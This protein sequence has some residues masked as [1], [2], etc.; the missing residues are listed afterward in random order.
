MIW[1]EAW[2]SASNIYVGHVLAFHNAGSSR[3][4]SGYGILVRNAQH[5]VIERSVALDNGWLPGNNGATGGIQ[6]ISVAYA[7][8]QYNESGFNHR[9]FADGDG[10]ILDDASRSVMQFN[11]TH[12]NEGA[13]L[14]LYSETPD[15]TTADVV[16]RY[17]ISQNDARASGDIYG[18]IFIGQVVRNADIY[19]NTI[20][21]TPSSSAAP[22]AFRVWSFLGSGIHVRNNIF[23]TA[24][25]SPVVRYDGGGSDLLLQGNDYWSNGAPL[26]FLWSGATYGDLPSWRLATG[27]EKVSGAAAGLQVDPK[28]NSAGGGGTIGNAD[29]L[30][31][32]TAYQLLATSPLRSAGLDLSQFGIA[33][34]PDLYSSDPFLSM[35]FN[36]TPTDFY[37]NP[38]PPS[39]SARFSIGANES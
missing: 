3:R 36:V 35:S 13:G 6:A 9:G 38:L 17:N 31:T 18:G 21:M 29:Q 27:Q 1:S 33:W 19:G 39:G 25:G 30:N 10:V 23:M 2:G 5:V 28:L 37:G 7:L 16:V 4:Q 15:I 14:L 11:Y 26:Q 34:D 8:L 20:H 24:G 22:A 12:D 32:L